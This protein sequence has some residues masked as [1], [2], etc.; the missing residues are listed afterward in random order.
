MQFISPN[1][2]HEKLESPDYTDI[3]DVFEDRMRNWLL[4]PA[5]HLLACNSGVAAVALL[6]GYFEGIEIY[7]TGKDSQYKSKE[8]FIRGFKRVFGTDAYSEHVFDELITALYFQARCG[9][10]HDGL[11]R[12]RVFFSYAKPEAMY[13][14]WPRKN[15]V[16]ITDG[17]LESVIINP[18]RFVELIYIHFNKYIAALRGGIDIQMKM[19]FQAAVELKWGLNDPDLI[20]GMTEEEFY[21]GSHRIY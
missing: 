9:F 3:V 18:S 4:V 11:F 21:N 1:F 19:N 10:A 5:Q 14:T 13:I 2:T 20:V 6:I 12:N 16:F 15:G 8:F 17:H 7:R